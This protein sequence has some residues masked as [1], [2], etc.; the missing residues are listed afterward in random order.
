MKKY[1]KK[2]PET[3]ASRNVDDEI[4]CFLE[5]KCWA[6][7][8]GMPCFFWGGTGASFF[9]SKKN[10]SVSDR[11]NGSTSQSSHVFSC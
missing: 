1:L 3:L 6:P 9:L 2:H 11:F 10:I 5:L 4:G 8:F 7:F